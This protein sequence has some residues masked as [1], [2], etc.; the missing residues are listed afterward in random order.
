VTYLLARHHYRGAG[1]LE[2]ET[3]AATL[4][5][6]LVAMWVLALVARPCTW[7]RIALVLALGAGFLIVLV[8]PWLQ[9]FF[10]LRLVGAQGPW[11]AVGVAVAASALLE[12]VWRRTR[13]TD[14]ET[15]SGKG[16]APEL[17]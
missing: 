1:A 16:A 3:S 5:L 2:A 8:T 14:E 9:E 10:A 6:F 13:R 12:L 11:T 4:T 17:L 7:W 15:P